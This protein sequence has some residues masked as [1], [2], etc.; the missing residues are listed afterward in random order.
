MAKRLL[1]MLLFITASMAIV[2]ILYSPMILFNGNN[3]NEIRLIFAEQTISP[4]RLFISSWRNVK[5]MYFDEALNNQNWDRWKYKY[6]SKIKTNDDVTVAINTMIASLDD[7]YSKFFNKKE[8]TLQETFIRNN[9]DKKQSLIDK[10]RKDYE[11][12]TVEVETIAGIATKAKV[13]ANSKFFPNPK[14]GDEIININ[15]YNINGLEINSAINLIRGTQSYLATVKVL[16]NNE[17]MTLTLPRGCLSPRKIFCKKLDNNI[18]QVFIYTFMG[19]NMPRM[20]EEEIKKYP[21]A[22]SFI[23]DLRGDAGGQALNGL[24]IAEKL[25]EGNKNLISIKYR[26][27]SI[28]PIKSEKRT[29]LD[30]KIP[31]VVLVDRRTASA[32]EILAG[33]LQKNN[34]AIVVGEETYGKNAIQQ[35]IPLPN[36]TCLNLTTSYYSFGDDFDKEASKVTPDYIVKTYSKDI[37]KG[38][39]APLEKAISIISKI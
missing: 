37:I 14:V 6:L 30:P 10:I 28:I 39:D 4:Q 31:I 38:K 2:L 29:I 9:L 20:F 15:G 34:R 26:N 19:K 7:P 24:F 36:N 32:S 18:I 23:I 3:A 35:I 12:V 16:R 1:Q 27:G 5:S 25:L 21:D 22:K 11:G 17:I 8:Y 13:C 33:I